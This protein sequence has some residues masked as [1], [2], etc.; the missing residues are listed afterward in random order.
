MRA[1]LFL[2]RA[3]LVHLLRQKETILWTFLMP[4]LFFWFIG[5]VTG[6]GGFRYTFW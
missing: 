3:D 4:A 6:G 2:A 5:T 1:A